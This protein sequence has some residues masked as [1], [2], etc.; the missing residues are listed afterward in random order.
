MFINYLKQASPTIL[1]FS[2]RFRLSLFSN[3]LGDTARPN[4]I[5]F[6]KDSIIDSISVNSSLDDEMTPFAQ[7]HALVEIIWGHI[8]QRPQNVPTVKKNRFL[9]IVLGQLRIN[10]L[11]DSFYLYLRNK[12]TQVQIPSTAK[13]I[14]PRKFYKFY[15]P[16]FYYPLRNL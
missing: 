11:F 10:S 15:I 12:D 5:L 9:I 13:I 4:L 16:L 2:M 1:N 3:V 6:G 7:S 14:T 8:T